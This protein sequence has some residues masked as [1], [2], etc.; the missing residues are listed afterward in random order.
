[1]TTDYGTV[2]GTAPADAV[3]DVA[4]T[5]TLDYEGRFLRRKRLSTDGGGTVLV[6]LAE[7]TNLTEETALLLADGRVIA[8]KPADEPLLQVT[9]AHLIRLAW[10]IGNRHTP[11]QITQSAL[12]IQR[13]HVLAEMLRGL[14]GT[15]TEVT[16]PFRPEGGA[17]GHGRTMGHSHGPDEPHHHHH[18]GH[19]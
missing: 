8:V 17:Y 3:Q 10:H 6:N 13:D 11:C 18:H 15:V 5:V 1:M 2:L 12:F 19:G 9:G 4:D 16:A 14:G 7:T